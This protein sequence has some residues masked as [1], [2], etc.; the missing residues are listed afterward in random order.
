LAVEQEC[1]AILAEDAAVP[2]TSAAPVTPRVSKEDRLISVQE[3]NNR[4]RVKTFILTSLREIAQAVLDSE[5]LLK[6]RALRETSAARLRHAV[7]EYRRQRRLSELRKREEVFAERA[8]KRKDEIL[9]GAPPDRERVKPE[10]LVR[11]SPLGVDLEKEREIAD[12]KKELSHQRELQSLKRIRGRKERRARERKAVTFKIQQN[13]IEFDTR[14]QE[15][16]RQ[17]PPEEL[18]QLTD[19]FRE[20]LIREAKERHQERTAPR[21]VRPH[22]RQE[23]ELLLRQT[24]SDVN[25]LKRL[26]T[27]FGLNFDALVLDA[28]CAAFV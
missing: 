11:V 7:T 22:S 8:D 15:R 1:A 27:D 25:S 28:D 18:Q 21:P 12:A 13:R 10:E 23:L 14:V 17:R 5:R 16:L 2:N 9:D 24:G 3:R 20:E 19:D 26:A 4:E 6:V